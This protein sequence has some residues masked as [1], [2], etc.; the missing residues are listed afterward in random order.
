MSGFHRSIRV[1]TPKCN[2]RAAQRFQQRTLRQKDLVDEI[3][4]ADALGDQAIDFRQ[5]D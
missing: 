3:Q 5:Q 2:V 1:C 4:V